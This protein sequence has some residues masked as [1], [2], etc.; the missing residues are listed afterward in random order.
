MQTFGNIFFL[1]EMTGFSLSIVL[2]MT[3]A[4]QVLLRW[5]EPNLPRPIKMPVAL[6][7]FL[8]VMNFAIMCITV[9]M[10][11][12]ESSF[13]IVVIAC[14][15]PVYLLGIKWNKPESIQRS[16]DNFTKSL[17]KLLLVTVQDPGSVADDDSDTLSS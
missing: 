16:L 2:I 12:R 9:Y 14:A 3:F 17:Q 7:A 6:P 4:G 15:I 13:A 8:I 5:T 11:P 10:K 1:I